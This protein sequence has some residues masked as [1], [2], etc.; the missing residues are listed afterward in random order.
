[1]HGFMKGFGQ[2]APE[3]IVA[4]SVL[5]F[6]SQGILELRRGKEGKVLLIKRLI[7]SSF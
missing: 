5:V 2:F 1:M 3:E 7:S 6:T 4:S